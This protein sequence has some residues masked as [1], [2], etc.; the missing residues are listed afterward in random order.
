M[1]QSPAAEITAKLSI[2]RSYL[3]TKFPN[4]EIRAFRDSD[5]AYIF[6]IHTVSV[7][8]KLRVAKAV[9]DQ[10]IRAETIRARL[11]IDA[12]ARRIREANGAPYE[13]N[14]AWGTT[15]AHP[16]VRSYMGRPESTD[17]EG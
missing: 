13:W 7:I 11:V 5:G 9:E 12:V 6:S 4:H 10:N 1:T 8:Y 17:T 14:G 2:I 15:P 16:E 3:E